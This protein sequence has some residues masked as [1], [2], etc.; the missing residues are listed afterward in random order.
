MI[1]SNII[2]RKQQRIQD[3]EV[4]QNSSNRLREILN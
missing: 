1:V 4:I 3:L 2:N